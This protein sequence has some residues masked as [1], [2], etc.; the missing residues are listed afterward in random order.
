MLLGRLALPS[1]RE[2]F[3]LGRGAEYTLTMLYKC[4]LKPLFFRMDPEYVHDRMTSNGAFFGEHAVSRNIIDAIYNY[5][6]RDI[7]KTVDGITY[8]TP[9]LLSAGF[10]YNGQLPAILPHIGLGGE[11][12][13][14]VT[15]R[16]CEGNPKPRLTRLPKS[17]SILVNKGLRNEGVDAIIRR[18]KKTELPNRFVTGISIARTNDAQS[19]PI[20]AGIAD[21]VYSF[22]RLNEENVGDYYTLNISCPNAYGAEAFNDPKLLPR[23]LE[24]V[25][26]IQCSKPIY[27]KM[28]INIP[29]TQ[30]DA[31]L[32][33][34]DQYGLHGVVIGNLNKD[35]GS[36]EAR[37]EAP[38]T[39]K[40]GLSGKPCTH[41]STDLIYKT[42][43]AYGDR[44]TVIGV[45]GVM[46]PATAMEKFEAGAD[47]VQLIT[48]LIFEGPGLI[49]KLCMA[50]AER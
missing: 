15:A 11:E 17:K 25:K 1:G 48:G 3:A 23:L 42:R 10:D 16:A 6:G 12:I 9:F 30:F 34:I 47:L 36:L 49:K 33:I 14:S 8:R 45:G 38:T 41:L 43:E 46:S 31:L 40:G 39:F 7:S 22:K 13:G 2:R 21:Y 37:E 50:Y 20:E 19:V 32:R 5:R 35:Y 4:V 24:V 26:S 27:V 44:F 18:L 28:P 29:W